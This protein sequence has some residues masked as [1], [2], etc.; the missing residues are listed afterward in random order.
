MTSTFRNPPKDPFWDR[1]G[2]G[3]K[4]SATYTQKPAQR[5]VFI[6]IRINYSL[7]PNLFFITE[8]EIRVEYTEC[9]PLETC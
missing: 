8:Q 6:N 1:P 4:P 2:N 9:V 7:A 3:I 5:A